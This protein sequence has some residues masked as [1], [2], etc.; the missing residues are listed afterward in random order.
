M[1]DTIT[2]TFTQ[3]LSI[4]MEAYSV[5]LKFS[6]RS[7]HLLMKV[8]KYFRFKSQEKFLCIRKLQILMKVGQLVA[9]ILYLHLASSAARSKQWFV[10]IHTADDEWTLGKY[11]RHST[12]RR[13]ILC[14]ERIRSR[15]LVET[16]KTK[17]LIFYS[18]KSLCEGTRQREDSFTFVCN[19]NVLRIIFRRL[20]IL[21]IEWDQAHK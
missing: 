5:K 21:V 15:C 20:L 11:E 2:A 6:E 9:S 10:F 17:F 16:T 8:C 13:F 7:G 19:A 12:R 3:I 14:Y 4:N 1:D 18:C